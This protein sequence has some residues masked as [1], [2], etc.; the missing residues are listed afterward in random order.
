M[1]VVA[2]LSITS[3]WREEFAKFADYPYTLEVLEGA[4]FDKLKTLRALAKATDT[5][6]V[7]VINYESAWRLEKELADWLKSQRQRE[8]ESELLSLQKQRLKSRKA[9]SSAKVSLAEME[10]TKFSLVVCDES[11][12]IKNPTSQAIKSD[13]PNRQNEQAQHHPHGNTN[14]KQPLGLLLAVQVS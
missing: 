12:K 7:A 6:Q 3:V 10:R 13:A 11:S 5:L 4:S 1:L 9:I 8:L 2:P 14:H